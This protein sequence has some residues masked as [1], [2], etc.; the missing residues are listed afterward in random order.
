MPVRAIL[1]MGDPLLLAVAEPIKE[2]DTPELN[3]IIED[4][5]ETMEANDGAGLAA[6]QIG[7][8]IQLVIFGFDSN[9]RYPDAEEV[10]FTVLIN[11]EII[12]Q[13]GQYLDT[14]GC[15]SIPGVT[16]YVERP[17][18]TVVKTMGG[19]SALIQLS[20]NK[21]LLFTVNNESLEIERS[22][23]LG[24]KKILDS[25]CI[26]ISGNLVNKNKSF[27]WEIKK[28]IQT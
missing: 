23:F 28:N 1:K 22:I 3:Q 12:R 8:S 13:E 2:V 20:K 14:E 16:G 21:S 5:M 9:E 17:E 19:D 10:P 18:L 6:P 7:L 27:Y 11:P 24:G 25:T 26:T 4:M 15:L